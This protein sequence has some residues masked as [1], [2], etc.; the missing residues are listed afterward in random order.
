MSSTRR[1]DF[2]ERALQSG[3]GRPG[4]VARRTD[5]VQLVRDLVTRHLRIDRQPSR[6]S[7]FSK[8]GTRCCLAVHQSL[9]ARIQARA[10]RCRSAASLHSEPVRCHPVHADSGRAGATWVRRP[11][12]WSTRANCPRGARSPSASTTGSRSIRISPKRNCASRA[13]AAW[14]AAFRSATPDVPVNNII[15]DWNDLVY[16]GRWKEAV[17]QL[18]ATN[19][20]PEFTGRICPAPCEASCVLGI[21]QPPVTIKQNREKHRRARLSTKAGSIPSRR[22]SAPERKLRSSVPGPRVWRPR[23]N[24]AAPGIRSRSTKRPTASADC[25]ATASPNSKWKSTSSIAASNRC[26]PRA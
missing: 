2:T 4:A 26:Q 11:A 12:S 25:C 1:G 3:L 8:T 20:F 17:R 23:N 5:D 13:R 19:N 6:A 21:N 24:Y 18:H 22:S 9:P 10:R 16:R 7:G 14:I 15:P